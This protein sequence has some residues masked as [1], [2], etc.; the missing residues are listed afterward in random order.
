MSCAPPIRP[1]TPARLEA[2]LDAIGA[3]YDADDTDNGGRP[4]RYPPTEGEHFHPSDFGPA[5]LRDLLEAV[6]SMAQRIDLLERLLEKW[7]LQRAMDQGFPALHRTTQEFLERDREEHTM[8]LLAVDAGPSRATCIRCN[9]LLNHTQQPGYAHTYPNGGFFVV[10]PLLSWCVDCAP[11]VWPA[12][13]RGGWE[14]TSDAD[15]KIRIK[16]RAEGPIT[17]T[18]HLNEEDDEV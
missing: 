6:G 15:G 10:G 8:K 17:C 14:V 3:W 1:I 13:L 7:M 12:E 5:D 9:A 2:W 16:A 11:K 18:V 4:K